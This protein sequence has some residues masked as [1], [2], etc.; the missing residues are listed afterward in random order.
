VRGTVGLLDGTPL[1]ARAESERSDV[2]G[3]LIA[4]LGHARAL[5]PLCVTDNDLGAPTD[6]V[7]EWPWS[8]VHMVV[9]RDERGGHLI[10][11]RVR[12]RAGG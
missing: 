9:C 12:A 4:A 11:D 1:D 8:W 2:G 3:T 10:D 7:T 5:Y 6:R